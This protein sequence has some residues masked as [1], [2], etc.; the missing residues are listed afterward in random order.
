MP[1]AKQPVKTPP[2]F[3]EYL[4]QFEP[5]VLQGA[6]VQLEGS[7]GW[8]L[9]RAFLKQRQREFEVASLDLSGHT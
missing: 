4:G 9:L 8:S 7:I 6:V 5:N 3:K 2:T 1:K